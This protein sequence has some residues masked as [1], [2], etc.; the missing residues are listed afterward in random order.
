TLGF[1]VDAAKIEALNSGTSYIEAVPSVS[2]AAHVATGAFRA[3]AAMAEL[4][5][6]DVI[7]I[8]VPTPLSRQREPD[9]RFVSDTA[10]TIVRY[11]R[12]GQLVVLESTTYPGTTDEVVRP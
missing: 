1:D 10:G 12:P 4:A 3:T 2:I 5:Q 7:V 6:C 11:L 8:C 9:L